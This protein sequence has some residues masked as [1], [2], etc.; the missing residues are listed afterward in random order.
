M[1]LTPELLQQIDDSALNQS[2]RAQLRCTIAKELEEAGNYEAGREAM[3]ELWQG[4]G[5][6]PALSGLDT[7]TT[8]EVL[9]R[10][11]TLSGWIGSARQ[12]AEAQE[13]AKDLLS[14]SAAIFG[15]L[16]ERAKVAEVQIEL[17]YCYWREGAFDEARITLQEALGRLTEADTELRS[18]AILRSAIVE[19]SSQRLNDALRLLTEAA[20]LFEK[21]TKHSLRGRFHVTLATTLKNLGTTEKREDYIDRALVEYSAASFHFEQAGHKRYR[22]RVENNLGFL[23]L[24]LT[25]F[26]EAHEHLD[27]ARRLFVTLKDEGSVAQVDETRARALLA[28]GLNAEAEKIVRSAVQTL[29]RGGEQALLAE[30]LTTQGLAQARLKQYDLARVTLERALDVA[31]Q[32]GDLEGAGRAALTLIEELTARLSGD[33]LRESY[34][35]ADQLLAR[36][37]H[38][39]T[40]AR[41]RECARRVIETRPRHAAAAAAEEKATKF[42]YAANETAALLRQ[43]LRVAVTDSPV[44]LTGETG[45]GKEVLAHL[46]HEWSGRPGKFV[47]INCAALTDTLSES[48]LFGHKKGSFAEAQ[49]DYPGAVR[50]A[51]GG[52]L[53]LDEVGELS[54]PNQGKLLRLIERG[55]VHAIG[56]SAPERV[57]VRIIAVT[58]HNL[59]EQTAQGEFRADLLY[60]LQT[61]HL[62]IPPLRERGEDIPAIAAHFV[63]EA[64]RTHKKRV[65]FTPASLEAMRHLPLPGNVRELRALIERTV[66]EATDGTEI[67]APAVETIALRQTRK[68]AFANEWEGCSLVEEV[69]R[70]E[71]GLILRALDATQGG[72]TRAARLL[73]TTHQALIAILN[74]RHQDLLSSRKPAQRRRRSIIRIRDDEKGRDKRKG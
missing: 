41:L 32:A 53:L 36:T 65:R 19:M 40:I 13:R 21:S 18:V 50:E 47:A 9:L 3:G 20:A 57:N 17:A 7:P 11:G 27:C 68:A 46:I 16:G 66:L 22:A 62:N 1:N 73:G 56:A 48:Q 49:S 4:V 69:L 74:T 12:I 31:E 63:E 64:C 51:A 28:Q 72:V 60:R 70:Y 67:S 10:T 15:K 42:V 6:Q 59:K 55:E 61:F 8:A 54:K 33:E 58:N 2:E 5:E 26:E 43:A 38:T 45:T 23:F 39:E 14:L 52:T 24:T 71:K 44:L 30:A 35:R 29:E 34:G 25:K 37:K